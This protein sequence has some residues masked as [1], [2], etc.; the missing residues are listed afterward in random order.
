MRHLVFICRPCLASIRN[1][2]TRQPL[3][4]SIVSWS[5]QPNARRR[6]TNFSALHA[7]RRSKSTAYDE[8]E[9]A[10]AAA[11]AH[12]KP[13][14]R[15][16]DDA[17]DW[18]VPSAVG[19]EQRSNELLTI[20]DQ[21]TR[22]ADEKWDEIEPLILGYDVV[23]K[24][25]FKRVGDRGWDRNP[26]EWLC[27]R[28]VES[29]RS[30]HELDAHDTSEEYFAAIYG[31]KEL[32]ASRSRTERRAHNLFDT[33]FPTIAR[34]MKPKAKKGFSL[35][36]QP[37][38][39]EIGI[40]RKKW[41]SLSP[42]LRDVRW[43]GMVTKCLKYAPRSLPTVL[44]VTTEHR[45]A[46]PYML[47][48][49]IRLL[50][51]QIMYY[52]AQDQR[53][54][55][56]SVVKSM[57]CVL[58][59]TPPGS[60]KFSQHTVFRMMKSASIQSVVEL[61]GSLKKY[62]WEFGLDTRMHFASRLA[63]DVTYRSEGLEIVRELIEKD[64]LDINSVTGSALATSLLAIQNDGPV[65]P[66]RIRAPPLPSVAEE[67]NETLLAVGLTPNIINFTA[68][69]Q[70]LCELKEL[71]RAWEVYEFM[72][73]QGIEP[74]ETVLLVLLHGSKLCLDYDSA[75]RVVGMAIER[76][77]NHRPFWNE[78]LHLIFTSA[79]RERED[80][81]VK[82]AS[83]R[84]F[85]MF[86]PMWFVYNK[87][88]DQEPLQRLMISK[89][90][91]ANIS[92]H[93]LEAVPGTGSS[94]DF[95][96][97][98]VRPTWPII[99]MLP[100]DRE[101]LE[102]GTDTLYIMLVAY[103]RGFTQPFNIIA[104]WRRFQRLLASGDPVAGQIV[105]EAGPKL[106]NVI[107]LSLCDNPEMLPHAL[108]MLTFMLNDTIE[109]GILAQSW[110]KDDRLRHPTPDIRSWGIVLNGFMRHRRH[111]EGEAILDMMRRHGIPPNISTWNQ[112]LAG[113]TRSHQAHRALDVMD[114]IHKEGLEP[115]EFTW[116]I[117]SNLRRDR[118]TA[119]LMK[120]MMVQRRWLRD[121]NKDIS[122]LSDD[123][124]NVIDEYQ[125][126]RNELGDLRDDIRRNGVRTR[127]PRIPSAVRHV[128][129]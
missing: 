35:H 116:S 86:S 83:P 103:V 73:G 9:N 46:R 79:L 22:S 128:M 5:T 41:L 42:R 107:L 13:R 99:S 105:R 36:P 57:L 110:A 50:G 69:I 60:V 112:L 106:H 21:D 30:T 80:L 63:K 84:S 108:E 25:K 8:L 45:I 77:M 4:R 93:S 95:L 72:V 33:W 82:G 102:P 16:V 64:R 59:N 14:K 97:P 58:R 129:M 11:I 92:H 109:A 121:N 122:W 28:Y 104:F 118:E 44:Q 101:M 20:G 34:Q 65:A 3:S 12:D 27:H 43:P 1:Q 62:E 51:N 17:D 10:L 6:P 37:S 124:R 94:L 88:F 54:Y 56:D 24:S 78:V 26:W 125:Q 7:F 98:Y 75:Q 90:P 71:S 23:I 66:N 87:F 55:A 76:G 117:F 119:A 115:D 31:E 49:V 89:T 127:P 53:D 39:E 126:L 29:S 67:V 123:K 15:Q 74:D 38:W 100:G 70:T 32:R 96:W 113:Y 81:R 52:R 91:L 40:M 114:R 85:S 48:Q 68:I 111:K 47:E 61:Y 120:K 2:Q 18:S 19:Q